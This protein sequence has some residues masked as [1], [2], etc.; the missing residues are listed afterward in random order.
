MNFLVVGCGSIGQRHIRNLIA[1]GH[2]VCGCEKNRR[3]SAM[4]SEKY[5]I[6]IYK[7]LKD[8]LSQ[9][10]NAAFI[11]TPTR[12]HIPNSI[13]I[14]KRDI[15]LFIEKPLSNSLS[16]VDKLLRLVKN[17]NLI[18]LVGC[19]IRFFP[20]F[21]MAKKLIEDGK[22]G[23]VLSVKVEFGFYLPYWHPYEDYRKS[24]SAN[25]SLGGGVILDDIHEIDSLVWLFGDVKEIFCFTG[26]LSNLEI[27]T[28]DIA[29]IFLKFK[30]GLI[31][32]IHLDYLQRTYRR[33]YEFIGEKGVIVWNYVKQSVELYSKKTNEWRVYQEDINTNREKMFIDEVKH[34]IN[35]IKGKENS[36][37]DILFAKKTLEV[38][39][40]CYESAQKKEIVY[41]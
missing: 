33:Y 14:A 25:K 20:T 28:E 2:K 1:L 18:T 27:D 34:F 10:Y 24:Y 38:A 37:N 39:L 30:S 41:L 16:G 23:E 19:N 36:V 35:C 4:V 15:H 12:E 13:E 17:K 9:R 40:A 21:I 3:K 31:A 8:A 26:K 22:I 11:C 32:Q 7:N 5:N 6:N 29:E